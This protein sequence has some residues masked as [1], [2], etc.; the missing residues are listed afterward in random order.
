MMELLNDT[1]GRPAKVINKEQIAEIEKLSALL[2]K[3]QLAEY[4]GMTE[5]TFRAIEERRAEGFY[6]LQ[7]RQ[8]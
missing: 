2:N 7:E 4:F 3:A 8:G 6:R 5:K 1:G